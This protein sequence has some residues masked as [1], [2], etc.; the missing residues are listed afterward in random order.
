[1]AA[2]PFVDMVVISF[3]LQLYSRPTVMSKVD[4]DQ[5]RGVD[6][7]LDMPRLPNLRYS[8]GSVVTRF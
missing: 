2:F 5:D 8:L 4:I 1:M 3:D 7:F 6:I